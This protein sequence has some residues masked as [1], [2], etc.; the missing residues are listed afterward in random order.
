MEK[1]T[2]NLFNKKS[3]NID[4]FKSMTTGDSVQVMWKERDAAVPLDPHVVDKVQ[5]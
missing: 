4:I 5:I 1:Q 3:K 2:N